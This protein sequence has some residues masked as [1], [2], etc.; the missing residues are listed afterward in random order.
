[1]EDE[2]ETGAPETG[3]SGDG[4]KKTGATKWESGVTR[5]PAN[6]I[7]VTKWSDVVGSTL[8]RG[9]ANPLSEQSVPTTKY[10]TFWGETIDIPNEG[11]KVELWDP[12]VNRLQRFGGTNTNG[13]WS[14]TRKMTPFELKQEKLKNPNSTVTTT[15]YERE[16]PIE[17]YL[18]KLFPDGTIDIITDL[19][20][21]KTYSVVLSLKDLNAKFNE[22]VANNTS[23]MNQA[24]DFSR[25]PQLQW[26]PKYAYL[27]Y[28]ARNP[29]GEPYGQP[30][31]FMGKIKANVDSEYVKIT[32]T[33][34]NKQDELKRYYDRKSYSGK[35]V[36]KGMNPNLYDEY[37]Y[38]RELI[39]KGE[40]KNQAALLAELDKQYISP[41]GEGGV[42]EFSYGIDPISR[43]AFM[44]IKA[45]F[46]AKYNPLIKSY[47][48][49]LANMVSYDLSGMPVYDENYSAVQAERNQLINKR[50]Q[51][52]EILR[53][54]WGYDYWKPSILGKAID[55]W[56]DKWGTAVQIVGN[57]AIIV[58]SGGIAGLFEGASAGIIRAM[59]PMV[60]DVTFNALVG[61]YQLN[62]GQDSEAL[63]SFICAFLPIAKYGFNVGK[64]SQETATKLATKIRN[65]NG[66][67]SSKES[68]SDFVALLSEEE[69]YIF[70]NVMSL[71]KEEIQ[72][73]FDLI[74][75]DIN[76]AASKEGIEIGKTS[77]AVWGKP[78]L[79]ELG[80]EF[81]VPAASQ[82]ANTLT[83]FI[84]DSTPMIEWD[85]ESLDKC[86]QIVE[87]HLKR[88]K[89]KTDEETKLKQIGVTNAVFNDEQLKADLKN[90]KTFE[91]VSKNI[92]QSIDDNARI[93][94]Q[95][96]IDD[97]KNEIINDPE[98]IK[99]FNRYEELRK[100][101]LPKQKSNNQTSTSVDDNKE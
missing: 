72:K 33:P 62:R 84:V 41:L 34:F 54:T 90:R 76:A 85:A 101:Y 12:T 95:K 74:L 26:M 27:Y 7:G 35:D 16:V 58:A 5:G 75:K 36:P 92:A 3:T 82:I 59:A 20:T 28:P 98:V 30:E 17:G 10:K 39:L 48:D 29:T 51:E 88:I 87:D 69:R 77:F 70:R 53:T 23:L 73:G 25:K 61:A 11:Y 65:A 100:K 56:W 42:P 22:D 68:L 38:K 43:N 32:K 79:K 81:G 24:V 1:M 71:P 18:R 55:E 67:L 97:V 44:A 83:G 63:I 45:K 37:L 96:T 64:V 60:A 52:Y 8:K 9:K 4:E 50:D 46:D 40:N 14:L 86:R 66:L 99:K 91:E 19:T 21:K 80:L 78:F 57:M 94:G 2:P 6:Q 89:G 13:K 47:D 31:A 49:K 15:T 93:I